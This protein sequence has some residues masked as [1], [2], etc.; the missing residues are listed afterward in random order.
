MKI[1]IQTEGLNSQSSLNGRNGEQTH[2]KKDLL[3]SQ[4][5]LPNRKGKKGKALRNYIINYLLALR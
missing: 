3:P 5:K 4:V 1:Y 2:I